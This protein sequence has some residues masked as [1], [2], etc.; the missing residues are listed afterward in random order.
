MACITLLTD[1]GIQDE[2]AGV[3]K[4]V[5]LNIDPTAVVIDITHGISA[6]NVIEAAYTLKAAFDYFPRGSIHLAIVDP[7]VGTDRNI[8]AVPFNGH[9]LMA[10][11]NGLLWPIIGESLQKQTVYRVDNEKLYRQPVSRTFHGRDIFAPVAAYL[12]RGGR[13]QAL[14]PKLPLGQV[15]PLGVEAPKLSGDKEIE[16][17]VVSVDRFGNL[18]TNVHRS[19]LSRLAAGRLIIQMGGRR[20]EDWV[21]NY[22]SGKSGAPVA[23]MG[24]RDCLEIA[25]NGGSAAGILKVTLGAVIRVQALDNG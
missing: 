1:F 21:E 22:A 6:Q 9:L 25:V 23:I 2:Y 13:V 11:N 16:G 18:V 10:P 4:G 3:L 20:I 7:G 19:D 17:I 15:E 14:G 5:I 8:I 24:S 12:S